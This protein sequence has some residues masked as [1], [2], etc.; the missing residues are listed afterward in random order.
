[1][2][3][4]NVTRMRLASNLKFER[5]NPFLIQRKVKSARLTNTMAMSAGRLH[6]KVAIVTGSTEG[7]YNTSNTNKQ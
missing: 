6:G 5:F 7:Y 3:F 1:M 2:Q 4:S